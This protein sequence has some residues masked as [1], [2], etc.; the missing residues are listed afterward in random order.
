MRPASRTSSLDSTLAA[1]RLV[2]GAVALCSA[3][4]SCDAP[5]ATADSPERV[6]CQKPENPYDEDEGA[7]AGFEWAR[8]NGAGSCG[9][10]HRSAIEGCAEFERQS[11]AYA[12]C[13]PGYRAPV[14]GAYGS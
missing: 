6:E 10:Y 4:A 9:R 7:Y 2:I 3:C 1:M 8:E 11:K 14:G 13:D 5:P 12:A